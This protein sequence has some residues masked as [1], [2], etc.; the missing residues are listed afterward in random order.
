MTDFRY[1]A[2]DLISG[3]VLADS[4]PL[5]VQSFSQQINGGGTLTA[6]LDLDEVYSV[7]RPFIEAVECR[8]S[9]IWVLADGYPV[10]NGVCWDWPDMTRSDGTLSISAQTMDSVWSHRLITATLEYPQVDMFTVFCD[11]VTYGM[12]KSSA[13]I[14]VPDTP[15]GL[16]PPPPPVVAAA[17]QVAGIILPT[18]A[19]AVCGVP[20]T[21]SYLWSDLSQV[22][23]AFSDMTQ[24]GNMEYVF[25]AGMDAGR[26]LATYIRL[27]YL[28]LGRT[29][30]E[31]GY[32][33]SYPGNCA[34][35][36]Y[37]RSGSTS[38]NYIWASAPPNG[39]A[40]QWESAYPHGVDL[41]DLEAGYPLMEDTV[42][43]EGSVVTE[44][45]Q[46]DSF[47]DGIVALR[48][49]AQ[50]MPVINVAGPGAPA[51]SDIVLGDVV[52]FVATSALH[53]PGPNGAPGLQQLVRISGWTVYPPGP[54]QSEYVQLATSGVLSAPVS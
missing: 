11:L 42:S 10:W 37:Q 28:A 33:L 43:W 45:S 21:A 22:A 4:L 19:A 31:A 29:G 26:N 14:D 13:Y 49:Q 2:T 12:T 17:A 18:G 41:A 40:E 30:G 23:E 34:D 35:Y 36:G 3:Q 15:A 48:T 25:Q 9:V 32:Q 27:G 54:Q 51:I 8:R 1:V 39:S 7:N 46:V 20:W 47:A 50:T 16:L 52:P 38:A 44:Q 5:N 24:S 53:P 6:T